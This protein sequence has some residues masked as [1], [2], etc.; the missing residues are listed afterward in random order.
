MESEDSMAV[1]NA[2]G[3]IESHAF[4]NSM[5]REK[6]SRNAIFLNPCHISDII[7]LYVFM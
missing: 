6:N 7:R 3:N 1:L 4:K 5:L 2:I